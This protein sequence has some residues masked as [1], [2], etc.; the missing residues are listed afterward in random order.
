MGE[1]GKA[2]SLRRLASIAAVPRFVVLD[3][4]EFGDGAAAGARISK[5]VALA[6]LR[7]PYAV[8]SSADVEDSTSAS[9]AGM[10]VTRLA[11]EKADL[12]GAV[13]AVLASADSPRLRSYLAAIGR[14][15]TA[16][17][18]SVIVQEMIDAR[19]A[20]VCVTRL[21]ELE[22]DQVVVEAVSGLG[23]TLVSGEVEPDRYRIDRGPWRVH[24]DRIGT[25]MLERTVQDGLSLVPAHRR[26]ARKLKDDE[27]REIAQTSV[28]IEEH[29]GYRA[30]D[31]EWAFEAEKLWILQ[32]R[33]VVTPRG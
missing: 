31:V 32:A 19:A 3:A 5:L 24:V 27:A 33:P 10:F 7:P 23:E 4:R 6:D 14:T 25:Q 30:A 11:V 12:S 1:G 29:L 18:V 22:P 16:P 9:F 21:P 13:R 2:A 20:G 28:E 15:G 26:R 17:L 8:R